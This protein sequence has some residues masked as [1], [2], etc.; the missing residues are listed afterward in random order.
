[1]KR[2]AT[3]TARPSKWRSERGQIG[4]FEVLPFGLLLFVSAM[5]VIVNA[6]AVVDAK[7]AASSAAREATRAYT[8]SISQTDADTSAELRAHEALAAYG[9]DG[10]R[11]EIRI[12]AAPFGR[13]ARV[14]V[15]VSY[16]VPALTVPF[17]GG[18]GSGITAR[19]R[20]SEIVDP[21]RSG[22][23]EGGCFE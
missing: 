21:Y 12:D 14:T 8:E 13:C 16:R 23:P 1:M 10:D 4:G 2:R 5:L 19:S 3:R 17:I 18:F 20:H 15:E 7:F 22:L 9:R 6:W 11:V